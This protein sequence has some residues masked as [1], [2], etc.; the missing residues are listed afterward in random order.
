MSDAN[1]VAQTLESTMA[2]QARTRESYEQEIATLEK[3][4][5]QLRAAVSFVQ[6]AVDN[7][8]KAEQAEAEHLAELQELLD[9][10]AAEEAAENKRIKEERE[11]RIKEAERIEAL[12]PAW[13]EAQS[14]DW[15]RTQVAVDAE[16]F[17]RRKEFYEKQLSGLAYMEECM[18]LLEEVKKN[19]KRKR[20]K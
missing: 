8:G 10:C 2:R 13:R 19:K 6:E 4:L 15:H 14:E 16:N 20:R 1:I 5:V 17:K 9:K 18:I 12:R 11:A 3:Q 7:Y